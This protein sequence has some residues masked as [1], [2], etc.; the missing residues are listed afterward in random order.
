MTTHLH[1][2]L[3]LR[4]IGATPLLFLYAFMAWTGTLSKSGTHADGNLIRQSMPDTRQFYHNE[5]L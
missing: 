5:G 3:G 2:V 1:L 4:M